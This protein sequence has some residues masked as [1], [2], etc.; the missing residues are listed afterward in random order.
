MSAYLDHA[1]TTPV[2]PEAVDAMLPFFTVD[3]G[4][5]SGAHLMARTARR[6]RRRRPRHRRRGAWRAA[7]PTS[8]SRAAVPKPTT[9]RSSARSAVAAALPFVRPSS[10]T[11]SCIP[12]RLLHGRIVGV[13]ARGIIDLEALERG[14]RRHGDDRVG[15]ARQQRERHRA[16]DPR[17]GCGRAARRASRA[18]AHRCGQ[19]VHVGRRCHASAPT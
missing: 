13:D 19:R 7:R 5:P 12:S 15:D 4:N 14:A 1:A 16:A 9:W 17:R 10:T 8:S 6:A 11:P 18:A 2:R 3:Y